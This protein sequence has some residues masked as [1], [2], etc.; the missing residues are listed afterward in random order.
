MTWGDVKSLWECCN[1]GSRRNK[2]G[3]VDHDQG[4]DTAL[5]LMLM[6]IKLW[7]R[8]FKIKLYVKEVLGGACFAVLCICY[9]F[10]LLI[11][12]LTLI[13]TSTPS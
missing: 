8:F 9:I 2:G 6:K 7:D 12:I 11:Y 1:N 5:L 10:S 4:N 13:T 3:K